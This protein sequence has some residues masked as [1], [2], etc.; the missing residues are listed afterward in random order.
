MV[1]LW[2]SSQP[3]IE[4]ARKRLTVDEGCVIENIFLF[5]TLP[6]SDSD[7]LQKTLLAVAGTLTPKFQ[8]KQENV[9]CNRKRIFYIY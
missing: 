3:R 6:N 8:K 2:V 9:E 5:V 1:C 7:T 4:E